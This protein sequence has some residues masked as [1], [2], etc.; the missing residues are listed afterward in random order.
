MA[1]PAGAGLC[2]RTG[3]SVGPAAGSGESRDLPRNRYASAAGPE[4]RWPGGRL[5][6][7]IRK[8]NNGEYSG[9]VTEARKAIEAVHEP[10]RRLKAARTAMAVKQDART[11]GQRLSL[12]RYAIYG[13][14]SPAAHG[15]TSA[16]A[17][18]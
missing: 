13:L 2:F 9:A 15:D 10:D 11:L 4:H 7:A 1:S 18:K 5:R 3:R 14:A 8:V 17:V 6:E 16:S 12:A